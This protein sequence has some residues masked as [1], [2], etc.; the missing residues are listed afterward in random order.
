MAESRFSEGRK[1]GDPWPAQL[2]FPEETAMG[3]Q[4]PLGKR[5][6][7]PRPAVSLLAHGFAAPV[8]LSAAL[9]PTC[10]PGSGLSWAGLET[11]RLFRGEPE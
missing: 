8:S 9:T 5:E 7:T 4:R 2:S 11:P 6:L 1:E 3:R 10:Q